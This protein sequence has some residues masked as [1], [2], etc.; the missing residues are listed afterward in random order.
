MNK[1]E[2]MVKKVNDVPKSAVDMAGARDAEIQWLLSPADETP[3]FS[4][5]LFTLARL[6]IT[7]KH[8]HAHEHEVFVLSGSGEVEIDGEVSALEPE[9]VAFVP[10]FALH[11]F[12][13]TG[14]EP[15]RFLCIIPNP[16]E[17]E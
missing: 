3:T 5:R 10:P 17:S 14:S 2:S 13:Q 11:Q 1:E 9:T 4:M 8:K 16:K 6:G 15:L 12:R 7:P